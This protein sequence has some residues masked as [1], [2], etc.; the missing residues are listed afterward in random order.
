[1]RE[2]LR[3]LSFSGRA[4]GLRLA[5]QSVAVA[6]CL[7]TILLEGVEIIPGGG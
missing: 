7:A 4:A 2:S 5:I 6:F 1:V 3:W